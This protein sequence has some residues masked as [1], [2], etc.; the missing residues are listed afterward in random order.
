MVILATCWEEGQGRRPHDFKGEVAPA[1]SLQRGQRPRAGG[2]ELAAHELHAVGVSAF[3]NA[4]RI[5]ASSAEGSASRSA[6]SS[7]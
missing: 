4:C 5:A 1:S 7:A 3:M 6:S 2:R